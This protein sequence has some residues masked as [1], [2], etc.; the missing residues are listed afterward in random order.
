VGWFV[1]GVFLVLGFCSVV[2]DVKKERGKDWLTKIHL[3]GN[4]YF[5]FSYELK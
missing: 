4:L 5:V 2:F 1:G 3:E